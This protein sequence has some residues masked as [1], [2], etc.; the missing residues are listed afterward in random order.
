MWWLDSETRTIRETRPLPARQVEPPAVPVNGEVVSGQA[1]V[2]STVDRKPVRKCKSPLVDLLTPAQE[3]ANR[4]LSQVQCG[5]EAEIERLVAD[6]GSLEKNIR[7]SSLKMESQQ[8]MIEEKESLLRVAEQRAESLQCSLVEFEG[9]VQRLDLELRSNLASHLA[10]QE[11][12]EKQAEELEYGVM[13]SEHRIAELVTA[14]QEQIEVHRQHSI[15]QEQHRKSEIA[16]FYKQ[17]AER[18]SMLIQKDQEISEL[19]QSQDQLTKAEKRAA[20]FQLEI[21]RSHASR[22]MLAEEMRR[23]KAT[24][25]LA[26]QQNEAEIA[27]A[28][29]QLVKA[30]K[31]AANFELEIQ[32]THALRKMLAEEM[33]RQKVAND[34]ASQQREAKIVELREELA[35]AETQVM[36]WQLETKRSHAS[37]RALA[38][39]AKRHQAVHDADL[40]K[41]KSQQTRTERKQQVA[42]L[43]VERLQS[44]NSQLQSKLQQEIKVRHQDRRIRESET[45]KVQYSMRAKSIQVEQ[46]EASVELRDR[47]I[48]GLKDSIIATQQDLSRAWECSKEAVTQLQLRDAKLQQVAENEDRFIQ[49]QADQVKT[50]QGRIDSLIRDVDAVNESSRLELECFDRTVK[51][52]ESVVDQLEHDHR[53]L[54]SALNL[55]QQTN[56]VLLVEA[57]RSRAQLSAGRAKGSL[58]IERYQKRLRQAI[59]TIETLRN[60]AHPNLSQK[61][62]AA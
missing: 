33:R 48:V 25:H 55:A 43:R 9:E 61:K 3:E 41:S 60:L 46:L 29:D 27:S 13:I 40:Q 59:E 30:E 8:A 58:L 57:A 10:S 32:R 50:L 7:Q 37:R 5:H 34:A 24:D 62:R 21:Q 38:E 6:V 31:R 15:D 4:I 16:A 54:T 20:N 39:Q 47:E 44:E 2:T 11:Q 18:D 49:I 14:I 56:T 36:T 53:Y 23:Q 51:G 12:H 35:S 28:K 26:L 45:S 1:A 52:L 19:K 17:L 42:Q 22:K